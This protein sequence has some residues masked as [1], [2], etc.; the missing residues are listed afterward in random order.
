MN[1]KNVFEKNAKIPDIVQQKANAAFREIYTRQDEPDANPQKTHKPAR[2]TVIKIASTVVA[3]A[4]TVV[5]LFFAT[6]YFG[7]KGQELPTGSNVSVG[8]G[9]V[10]KR[11]AIKVCAAELQPET[12]LPISLDVGHQSFGYGVDWEGRANY[13]ANF[14]ISVEGENISSVT[15]K[16]N[17]SVIEVVSIDC[18]SIVK[19]G[20][21]K[22][23]DDYRSTY[24][25][26]NDMSGYPI[27]KTEVGYYESFSADYATLQKSKYLL[28]ICNVLT[29][30]MD[31]YYLLSYCD[32]GNNDEWSALLT[33]LLKDV[34]ITIEVTFKDGTTDS[35]TLGLFGNL[36]LATDKMDDGTEYQ[37]ETVQIFCYDENE[38][39]GATKQLISNQIARAEEICKAGGINT[40]GGDA[41]EPTDNTEATVSTET[42]AD[43][44]PTNST[45]TTAGTE[46]SEST[47]ETEATSETGSTE[48]TDNINYDDY[49]G[50]SENIE[51]DLPGFD[52]KHKVKTDSW[53][54]PPKLE[55]S[56]KDFRID[57]SRKDSNGSFDIT[58]RYGNVV[59]KIES[60]KC[61]VAHTVV[62]RDAD[63]AFAI[64]ILDQSDGKVI[65]VVYEMTEKGIVE[66]QKLD[67]KVTSFPD[68]K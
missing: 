45:E 49:V 57:L 11:F 43:T 38:A 59:Q 18:P 60:A 4:I 28:N 30:R 52:S 55:K 34:R 67:G 41:T 6:S 20:S 31:L 2:A 27:G 54:A 56:G 64:L 62:E 44:E 33:Y 21:P 16:A 14:P 25:D 8:T 7:G 29:D 23:L 19:S 17:N 58:L 32:F 26:G 61:I 35:R 65:T 22:T 68:L 63:T 5:A 46:T 12:S 40:T 37:Y 13:Q 36:Y 1:N 3:A 9:T 24:V 39:D 51:F 53:G 48:N 47:G 15:F 66:I 10:E 50:S 42:T